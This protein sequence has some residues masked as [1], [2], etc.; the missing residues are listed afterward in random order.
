MEAF[1]INNFYQRKETDYT[2]SAVFSSVQSSLSPWNEYSQLCRPPFAFR[3]WIKSISL[4]WSFGNILETTLSI[5][6]E[7]LFSMDEYP[8]LLAALFLF[9][10]KVRALL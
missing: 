8:L 5:Q 4:L 10:F 7:K 3:E 6:C 2:S 1:R 9:T